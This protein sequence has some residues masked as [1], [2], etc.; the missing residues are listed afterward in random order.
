MKCFTVSRRDM[1][2][3]MHRGKAVSVGDSAHPMQPTHA[4]G[5]AMALESAAALEVLFRDFDPAH[6]VEERLALFNQLRLPRTRTVQLLS[7]AMLY[8]HESSE[9]FIEHFREHYRG[10]PLSPKAEGQSK[11]ARGFLYP[12]DAFAEA[13][14]AERFLGMEGGLSEGVVAHFGFGEDWAARRPAALR[15]QFVCSR[16]CRGAKDKKRS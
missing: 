5:A 8:Q 10:P 3:R 7:N 2:D 14:K 13:E 15:G 4:S 16:E 12:Y 9:D 6:F 1:V 11:E